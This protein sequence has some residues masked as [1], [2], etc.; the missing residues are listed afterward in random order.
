MVISVVGWM[1]DGG[2]QNKVCHQSMKTLAVGLDHVGRCKL[3]G[4][5]PPDNG[6]Q[7]L[8]FERYYS[9]S[10]I[11]AQVHSPLSALISE[12]SRFLIKFLSF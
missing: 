5:G 8:D 9:K 11:L 7:W 12:V 2:G 4:W 6:D 3:S 10:F 1:A